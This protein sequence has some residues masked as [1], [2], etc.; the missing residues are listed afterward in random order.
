MHT[1]ILNIWTILSS[2][3]S[4]HWSELL[5]YTWVLP[6]GASLQLVVF[7][8]YLQTAF[9]FRQFMEALIGEN[10]FGGLFFHKEVYLRWQFNFS[11]ICGPYGFALELFWDRYV[12]LPRSTEMG[13]GWDLVSRLFLESAGSK[14]ILW[15]LLREVDFFK[16]P[17][18]ISLDTSNTPLI[19]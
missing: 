9:L 11:S 17:S 18:S 4:E 12:G 8:E 16:T 7:G 10:L 14:N 5:V 1:S 3:V 15:A 6:T 13:P 2:F 19:L